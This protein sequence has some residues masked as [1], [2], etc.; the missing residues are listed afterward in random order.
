MDTSKVTRFEIIDHTPCTK[1][2]GS[3]HY[4]TPT[5]SAAGQSI[6]FYKECEACEGGGVIG[7][8][9]VVNNPDIQID[10]ELQDRNRTLKVFL[11][12]RY[13]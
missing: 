2:G 7:R 12:E 9:V 10:V 3:G 13:E 4:N 11:H 5:D 6:S 1:C 8:T